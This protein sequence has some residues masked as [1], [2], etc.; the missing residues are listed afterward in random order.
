MKWLNL[1][2]GFYLVFLMSIPCSDG[3][4]YSAASAIEINTAH[5]HEHDD[6]HSPEECT[7]FC[8]CS[9]CSIVTN[10]PPEPVV[11]YGKPIM[12]NIF[13][14]SFYSDKHLPGFPN[15]IW[16]PPRFKA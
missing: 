5:Q 16:Q 11:L 8:I 10:A 7:P 1:L 4:S 2:F 13:R 3:M 15:T 14:V 12:E 9:C 6:K